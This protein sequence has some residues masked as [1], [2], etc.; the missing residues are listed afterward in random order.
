MR[1]IDLERQFSAVLIPLGGLQHM[2]TAADV[3]AALVTVARHLTSRGLAVIDVEAAHPEDLEAGP[4][5]IVEHWTRSWCGGSV[6]KLVTVEGEPSR[7]LRH[8]TWHY[9][10]QPAD[11]EL[12]RVTAQFPLRVITAGELELAARLAGLSVI[13]WYGDYNLSPL[14]DHDD[15][16]IAVLE[17]MP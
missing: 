7:G 14:S 3:A 2:E 6:T 16:L 8:V 1:D 15:R 4:Q 12:H 10:I 9:D 11:G 5:P 13:D 17:R